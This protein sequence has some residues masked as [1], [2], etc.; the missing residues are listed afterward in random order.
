[1]TFLYPFIV[2]I[3]PG[4]LWPAIAEYKPILILSAVALASALFN[5]KFS[6]RLAG[7]QLSSPIFL[8]LCAYVCVQVASVHYGGI[9]SVVDELDFWVPYAL[10][11]A[12]SLVLIPDTAA[13]FRYIAG[14]LAGSAV[15]IGY[16][17]VAVASHSPALEGNRAGAYGL[18]A[19]HNDYTF[20]IIMA[21]PFAYMAISLVRSRLLKF[22][23]V[24]FVAACV[25]GTKL[26]LSRGGII[27]LIL[28]I[29][30]LYWNT[31]SGTSRIMGILA[32]VLGGILFAEVQFAAREENQRGHY[33]IE[34]SKYSRYEL[35][36]AARKVF[37]AHPLLGVGSRRFNEFAGNYAELSHSQVGKVT[38]NTYLEVATGSGAVGLLSFLA[39]VWGCY[40]AA[41]NKVIGDESGVPRQ[42]RVATAIAVIAIFA[43]SNLDAKEYD[44]SFYFLVV[45]A[46]AIST[47]KA[48]KKP[49]SA[50]EQ[51]PIAANGKAL[52]PSIYARHHLSR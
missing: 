34:D 21:L 43:R 33:S 44:W 27:V 51:L 5:P 18:Y 36:R 39:M 13:L 26:S 11:A 31:T 22:L 20:I 47:L 35:W 6:S 10:F 48:E 15:V 23:L 7:Q 32:L 46:I 29:I 41:S 52:R 3:Q 37:E 14:V 8:W 24:L 38:H 40:R 12:V 19:N 9:L 16:G 42:F 17:L 50:K 25:A 28:A 49:E 4:I 2:L 45:M 1:V 30:L